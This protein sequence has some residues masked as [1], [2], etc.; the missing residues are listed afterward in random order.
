MISRVAGQLGIA[1]ESIV[2]TQWADNGPGWIA[3][4][5]E[6]AE[7]V[8]A[9]RPSGVDLDIGVVGPYP[10]GGEAAFELRAFCPHHGATAEDPVTGSLNASVA[11]WLL[12]TGRAA[13]PYVA[14][15]G[16]A[17]GRDGR[18]HVTRDDDGVIWVG[19]DTITCFRGEAEV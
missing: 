2:A 16:T 12:R 1:R 14:R 13:A 9:L 15:Q 5:L 7:A 18:I 11:G 4:L 19:G 17:L 6:S 3:V 10:A 8:L